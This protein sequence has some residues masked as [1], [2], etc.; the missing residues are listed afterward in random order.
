MG[1]ET[2][3]RVLVTAKLENLE[4]LFDASRGRRQ[5]GEVRTVSVSDALVDTG[6]TSVA[7]PKK[8][9][10]QLGLTKPVRVRNIR[11]TRGSVPSNVYGPVKLTIQGRDCLV[12]VAEIDDGCPLLIGQVP[13]ELLDFVVDSQ[14]RKLIGNPEHGGEWMHDVF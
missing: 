4:D 8:M 9:I 13:L 10:D 7:M 3:G 2:M 14:G 6:C 11:T 1:E 12:D 5:A